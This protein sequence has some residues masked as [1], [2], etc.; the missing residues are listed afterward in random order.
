MSYRKSTIQTYQSKQLSNM[1]ILIFIKLLSYFVCIFSST[2]TKE[3]IMTKNLFCFLFIFLCTHIYAQDA[4]KKRAIVIGASV[5][6][7]RELCKILAAHNYIVGMASRRVE[8]LQ[9][10]QDEITSQTYIMQMDVSKTDETVEKLHAMIDQLG[11]LDIQ[12]QPC[13]KDDI[14][15]IIPQYNKA[16]L[17]NNKLNSHMVTEITTQC[18][19]AKRDLLVITL[20]FDKIPKP[21]KE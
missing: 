10:L 19:K 3:I 7:G 12:M 2:S 18:K 9:T 15:T 16:L 13:Q 14:V 11:G 17:C 1:L 4:T 21:V 20:Y 5:G 8:L 6:M